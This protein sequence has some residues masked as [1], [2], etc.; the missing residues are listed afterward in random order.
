METDAS[1]IRDVINLYKIKKSINLANKSVNID[2]FYNDKLTFRKYIT[3]MYE[4]LQHII[5]YTSGLTKEDQRI[6]DINVIIKDYKI[7]KENLIRTNGILNIEQKNGFIAILDDLNELSDITIER[8]SIDNI[9]IICNYIVSDIFIFFIEEAILH[10]ISK[11]ITIDNISDVDNRDLIDI[12]NN[13]DNDNYNLILRI[14]F[15]N[16]YFL[17]NTNDIKELNDEFKTKDILNNEINKLPNCKYKLRAIY[18]RD[19]Y[20]SSKTS[21]ELIKYL[22]EKIDIIDTINELNQFKE[23]DTISNYNYTSNNYNE[24]Y[25]SYCRTIETI[26]Y[27]SDKKITNDIPVNYLMYYSDSCYMDVIIFSLLYKNNK[28]ISKKI[29]N[30]SFEKYYLFSEKINDELKKLYDKLLIELIKIYNYIHDKKKQT[31]LDVG[32]S[33]SSDKLRN[34]LNDIHKIFIDNKYYFLISNKKKEELISVSNEFLINKEPEP[35]PVMNLPLTPQYELNDFVI[36]LFT[37]FQLNDLITIE[38]S[39]GTYHNDIILNIPNNNIYI[40]PDLFKDNDDNNFTIVKSNLLVL[41][42]KLNYLH[43]ENKYATLKPPPYLKLK[44]NKK[45]IY[46]QSIIIHFPNIDKGHYKCLFNNNSIWY[47]YD[48]KKVKDTNYI[49]D[50]I[51]T[52]DDI[53]ENHIYNEHITMLIYY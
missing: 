13:D 26:E 4:I 36:I 45:L 17:L 41:N 6:Q 8:I 20:S 14:L 47:M 10:L 27:N 21:E 31:I 2:H 35:G 33:A 28:F 11:N 53:I 1:T 52:L 37:I 39:D 22:Y 7:I 18:K 30:K 12:L 40:L 23:I 34:I 29:L 46:L 48:D 16:I 32:D 3:S 51:G 25:I 24:T 9:L 43:N 42:N 38:K 15:E 50:K 5:K 44:F 19:A 49:P